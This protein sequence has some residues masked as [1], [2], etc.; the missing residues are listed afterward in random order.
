MRGKKLGEELKEDTLDP[1]DWEEMTALGHRMLDDMMEYLKT[2]RKQPYLP[3]TEEAVKTIQVPL[4][5]KG[6]GGEKVY[7]IFREHI[8][9]S[10]AK[11]TRPDFW[12]MVIGTGSPFGMLTDMAIS[13]VNSG[14][15]LNFFI[16]RAA[17]YGGPFPR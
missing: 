7:D 2:I 10:S 8:I 3:P 15:G 6:D 12:G 5:E 14:S 11:W 17:Q 16:A 13:G 9:P 4:P 1:V